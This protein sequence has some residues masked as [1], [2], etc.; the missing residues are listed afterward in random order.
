MVV[1]VLVE[2]LSCRAPATQTQRASLNRD[3]HRQA[4]QEPT[5]A[6]RLPAH[7]TLAPLLIGF[8]P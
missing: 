8:W 6:N 7:L 5:P 2:M 1:D 4:G 3:S